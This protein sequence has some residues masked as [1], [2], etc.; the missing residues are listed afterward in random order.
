MTT[1]A[2]SVLFQAEK[3]ELISGSEAIAIACALA[4]VDVITA[5]PI[6][7]YDTVMQYVSKLK[8]DG[9]FDCDFIVAESEHSQFEIVKHASA[10]GART[11]CGSSGVGWFY[12]FEAITVTAGLRM[13]VVAMVGNRALDDPGRFRHRAQRCFG[14][15]GPGLDALLGGYS[16]GGA[17]HRPAGLARGR[18]PQSFPAHGH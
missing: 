3:E 4:D 18:R 14:G 8:A 10:V 16:P 9:V 17:G 11:F 5:Y 1:I 12:A 15:A 2:P 7:P 6:R 13:P